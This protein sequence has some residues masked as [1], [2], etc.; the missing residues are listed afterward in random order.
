MSNPF[1]SVEGRK[2]AKARKKGKLAKHRKSHLRERVK[3]PGPRPRPCRPR[4][5]AMYHVM[6]STWRRLA[7]FLPLRPLCA[8]DMRSHLRN[9][10][11]RWECAIPGVNLRLRTCAT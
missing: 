9:K 1:H 5:K 3:V 7:D 2:F 11:S 8:G 6:R 4:R 10:G